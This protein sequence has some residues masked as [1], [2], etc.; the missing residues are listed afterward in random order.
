VRGYLLKYDG[1]THEL[2]GRRLV[3]RSPGDVRLT[4]D[5]RYVLQSHYD[6]LRVLEYLMPRP[7]AEPES[8][9]SELAVIDPLTMDDV[10]FVEICPTSHGIGISPDSTKAYVSCTA[11]DQ[12]AIVTLAPPWDV[13]T[14]TVGTTSGSLGNPVYGPYA[15]A[16]DPEN[17]NVWVS[18]TDSRDVRVFDA[19]GTMIGTPIVTDPGAPFFGDFFGTDYVVA[20]QGTDTLAFIDLATRTLQLTDPLGGCMRPH[21]VMNMNDTQ[22]LVACEGD[23]QQRE[24]GA[25]VVVDPTTRVVD[26]S[27][28][29][30]VY[31]DDLILV[32]PPPP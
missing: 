13:V 11:T 3:D 4:P 23:W 32:N 31:P 25:V 17:G 12:V 27:I 1:R 18:N 26:K 8:P 6:L 2:V 7:D 29:V 30:G 15:I 28:P 10:A 14:F 19:T 22:I 16:V 9:N 20:L 5:E 21:A 24:P